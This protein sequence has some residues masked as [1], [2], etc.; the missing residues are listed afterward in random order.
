MLAEFGFGKEELAELQ[1]TQGGLTEGKRRELDRIKSPEN[2]GFLFWK[3]FPSVLGDDRTS[4]ELIVDTDA[5]D[6]ILESH[7]EFIRGTA[8]IGLRPEV[9][10]EV[11]RLRRPVRAELFFQARTDSPADPGR[12]CGQ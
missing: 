3:S 5:R 2:R 1:A 9:Q 7:P 11:F 10:I 8:E 6:M 4:R 12:T